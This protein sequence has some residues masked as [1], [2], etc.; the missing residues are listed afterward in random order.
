VLYL[1]RM[2]RAR[3]APAHAFFFGA[4]LV[5]ILWA[6]HICQA[7]V[8]GLLD[9]GTISSIARGTERPASSSPSGRP[10]RVVA[11]RPL[12]RSPIRLAGLY[13]IAFGHDLA[14]WY[15]ANHVLCLATGLL[16]Y[17]VVRMTTQGVAGATMGALVFLTGS[18]LAEATRANF[19]KAEVVMTFLS[20]LPS[21]SSSSPDRGARCRRTTPPLG[22]AMVMALGCLLLAAVA[23]ESAASSDWL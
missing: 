9:D 20:C 3:T 7:A 12:L 1:R 5:W 17:A 18:P 13:N 6:L 21:P 4:L 16:I 2:A 10:R 11:P 15:L 22:L 19:G 14:R 8:P 23:K